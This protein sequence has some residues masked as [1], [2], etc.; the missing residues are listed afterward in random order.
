MASNWCLDLWRPLDDLTFE[1]AVQ[2]INITIGERNSG[3]CTADHLIDD[4]TL[5]RNI[6]RLSKN[7]K[8]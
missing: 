1:E 4:Y 8:G 7:V 2:N 6:A 5:S 3:F